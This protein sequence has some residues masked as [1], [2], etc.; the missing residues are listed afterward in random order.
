MNPEV[1]KQA[2]SR[3]WM[4]GYVYT[5]DESHDVYRYRFFSNHT[6]LNKY[7]S[8]NDILFG[9]DFCEKFFDSCDCSDDWQQLSSAVSWDN[10][11]T[12]KCILVGMAEP[13]LIA[14]L[15]KHL[16]V[17]E[18]PMDIRNVKFTSASTI[19]AKEYREQIENPLGFKQVQPKEIEKIPDIPQGMDVFIETI[20]ELVTQV[21]ANTKAISA[22]A[23]DCKLNR[24]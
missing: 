6:G 4:E 23:K 5:G 21:N 18:E 11:T 3:G 10:T 15:E 20:N 22:C 9:T 8:L 7:L 24:G 19:S 1:F 14:F 2:Q 12:H 17:K 13:E 16:E